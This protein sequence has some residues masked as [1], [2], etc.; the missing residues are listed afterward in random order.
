MYKNIINIFF[1]TSK[2]SKKI[3]NY[4][5]LIKNKK[6][7]PQTQLNSLFKILGLVYNFFYIISKKHFVSFF[8]RL[9]KGIILTLFS[10]NY[11]SLSSGK[12]NLLNNYLYSYYKSSSNLLLYS[13]N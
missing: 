6:S 9:H 4:R 10:L 2:K 12:V 1:I 7:Y 3:V 8:K 5:F 13:F 11:S